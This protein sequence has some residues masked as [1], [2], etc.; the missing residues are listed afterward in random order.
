MVSPNF[1]GSN[2]IQHKN[3][4]KQTKQFL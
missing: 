1:G 3:K 2:P 4:S